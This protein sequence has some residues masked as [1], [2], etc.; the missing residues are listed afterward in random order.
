[1]VPA[2]CP[3]STKQVR[4]VDHEKCEWLGTAKVHSDLFTGHDG[5]PPGRHADPDRLDS[6]S[7]HLFPRNRQGLD[8]KPAGGRPGPE[9]NAIGIEHDPTSHEMAH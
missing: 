4:R 6:H 1:V 2:K 7:F 8:P 3:G 9:V 5:E